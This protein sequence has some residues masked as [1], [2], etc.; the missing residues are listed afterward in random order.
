MF[1]IFF[2]QVVC[3]DEIFLLRIYKYIVYFYPYIHKTPILFFLKKSE[4]HSLPVS[5]NPPPNVSIQKRV[6]IVLLNNMLPK[7]WNLFSL[8]NIQ[9]ETFK[10]SIKK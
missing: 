3:G 8:Y 6:P 1:W 10:N 4:F 7:R 2:N 5:P 9:F